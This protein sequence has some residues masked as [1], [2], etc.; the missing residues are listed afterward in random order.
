MILETGYGSQKYI[1]DC[2]VCCQP[3]E[4]KYTVERGD[5][6]DLELRKAE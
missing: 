3:I 6:V 4:V 1:E 5:I 2:E